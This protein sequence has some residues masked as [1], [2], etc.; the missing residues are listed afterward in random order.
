MDWCGHNFVLGKCKNEND[1]KLAGG[2]PATVQGG[3]SFN[4]SFMNY[5]LIQLFYFPY[6]KKRF[7]GK[8][9]MTFSDY[10]NQSYI[11][12]EI[13]LTLGYM[14][15]DKMTKLIELF[16]QDG[17]NFSATKA[18]NAIDM[19]V[20][21]KQEDFVGEYKSVSELFLDLHIKEHV[22]NIH[23]GVDY[24]NI[25]ELS[26]L[27]SSRVPADFVEF[28]S[29]K[30]ILSSI[31]FGYTFHVLAEKL[32]NQSISDEEYAMAVKSGLNI[33]TEK[34][35]MSL[36]FRTE[37][38]KEIIRPYVESKRPDLLRTLEL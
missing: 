32:F 20:Q 22:N 6:Y 23:K 12:F 26:K 29:N 7:F 5:Y 30:L 10:F 9:Y 13:S 18:I 11:L 8:R 4:S 21:S 31:G 35:D 17:S 3:Q 1:F 27:S 15:K 36:N 19:L 25:H 28:M 38:A 16:A 2:M 33:P 24:K 14:Y 37:N 34:F